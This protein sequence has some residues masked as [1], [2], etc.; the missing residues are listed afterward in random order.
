MLG[1]V[2]NSLLDHMHGDFFQM[3]ITDIDVW[4]IHKVGTYVIKLLFFNI[5]II[6]KAVLTL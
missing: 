1:N 2:L 4:S 5:K 6:I 3:N